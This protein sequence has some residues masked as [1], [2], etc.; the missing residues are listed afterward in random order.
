[1]SKT[2]LFNISAVPLQAAGPSLPPVQMLEE[3]PDSLNK[4][5]TNQPFNPG[6]QILYN[7]NRLSISVFVCHTFLGR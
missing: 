2:R 4:K 7:S 6:K 3:S 5:S 1:M